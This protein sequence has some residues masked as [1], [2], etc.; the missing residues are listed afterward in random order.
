MSFDTVVVH[1]GKP[2]VDI[3]VY[4]ELICS[5]SSYFRGSINH[6]FLGVKDGAIYLRDVS[7]TTFRTFLAWCHLQCLPISPNDDLLVSSDHRRKSNKFTNDTINSNPLIG[8]GRPRKRMFDE[9][10]A[11]RSPYF[12]KMAAEEVDNLYHKN[13]SW[14]AKYQEVVKSL[15]RLYIFAN[16]YS[17][18]QLKDDV[19]STYIGYCISYGFYP[20]PDDVEI[21]ELVYKNLPPTS[22]LSRYLVLSTIY[23][24]TPANLTLE[25][26]KLDRLHPR[27]TRDVMTAQ[28]QRSLPPNDG[29]TNIT[30]VVPHL[31]KYGLVNSCI[32]H[33]HLNVNEKYCRHRLTNSK[34]IFNGLLNACVKEADAVLAKPTQDGHGHR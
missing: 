8:R 31:A 27:F 7:E 26:G 25:S 11:G 23:F 19:M 2:S 1:V 33:E 24:W 29:E 21:I 15:I 16:K 22:M 28:A 14:Q 9:Y 34:F 5:V 30:K 20:D 12:R 6:S 10:V 3:L 32:F 13:P 18:H 17:I 4:K